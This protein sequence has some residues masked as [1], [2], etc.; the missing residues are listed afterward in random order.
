MFEYHQYKNFLE[1]WHGTT[2]LAF[3][4][5]SGII[6]S[7]DSRASM[8]KYIGSSS[9]KKV[10]QINEDFLGTMAGGAADCFFWERNLGIICNLYE[11][12]NKHKITTSGAAKI[13]SNIIYKYKNSGLSIG[14]MIIGWDQN[15][16]GLFYVDSSANRIKS[17]MISIGSGST[18]AY[19]ILDSN[20]N[21]N[22][23]IQ[24]GIELGRLAIYS[25]AFKDA[26]SGG[27]INTFLMRKKGWIKISSEDIGIEVDQKY[28][29]LPY[30]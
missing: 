3:V 15:G 28:R 21:W 9:V 17:N 25:A 10:I 6:I 26:Y 22:L 24:E 12:Q 19:G 7:V 27:K 29:N 13:F 18:F 5:R 23:S 11:L 30:F 16:P 8:G 1:F 4:L 20:Y 14:A 2:T